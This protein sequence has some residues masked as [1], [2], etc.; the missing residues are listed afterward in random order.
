MEYIFDAERQLK[1]K[2]VLQIFLKRRGIETT[3]GEINHS[4]SW[5]EGEFKVGNRYYQV[6]DLKKTMYGEPWFEYHDYEDIKGFRVSLGYYM[7]GLSNAQRTL[8][9]GTEH[10]YTFKPRVANYKKMTQ[11]RMD[12]LVNTY[13]E[14]YIKA[15][16]PKNADIDV[17]RKTINYELSKMYLKRWYDYIKY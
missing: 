1:M 7:I 13:I 14:E 3:I 17:L 10:V 11:K 6:D 9:I 15:G 8:C 16:S 5:K 4:G 2:K 12:W